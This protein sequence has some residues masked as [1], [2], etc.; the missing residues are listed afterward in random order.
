MAIC[1]SVIGV[2][3]CRSAREGLSCKA[4]YWIL[5]LVLAITSGFELKMSKNMQ[6]ATSVKYQFYYPAVISV[7]EYL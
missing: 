1:S 3:K 2:S 4:N 5:V 7:N 6:C